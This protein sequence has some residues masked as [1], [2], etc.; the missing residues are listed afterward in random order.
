MKKI[1]VNGC[2]DV[3]HVGHIYLLEYAKSLG[4]Y[5]VVAID[6]DERVKQLKGCNRPFNNQEDRKIMLQ[7]L[8]FVDFVFIFNT[9]NE[10]NNLICRLNPDIMVVGSDWKHKEVVG[11]KHAKEL[12]FF[13]RIGEYST[14]RVLEGPPYR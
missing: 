7:A 11:S 12:Q 14:T 13:E 1:F 4:D 6:S 8:K 9:E 5:L 2:F 3:L 10:L